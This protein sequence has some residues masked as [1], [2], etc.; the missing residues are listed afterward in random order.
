VNL[1]KQYHERGLRF[2]ICVTAGPV[3]VAH[4]IVP[5]ETKASRTVF[6]ALPQLPPSYRLHLEEREFLRKELDNLIEQGSLKSARTRGRRL[7]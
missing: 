6:D 7:L 3:T 5:D 4:E 1:L 2:V